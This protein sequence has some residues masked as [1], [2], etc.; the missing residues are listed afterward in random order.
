MS[1]GSPPS[2]EPPT[3]NDPR[4]SYIPGVDAEIFVPPSR[5]QWFWVEKL[6]SLFA[7]TPGRESAFARWYAVFTVV[8]STN[9]TNFS[10]QYQSYLND[11][12][13]T[14]WVARL[15]HAVAMPCIVTLMLMIARVL[16]GEWAAVTV[17]SVFALWWLVWARLERD[18]VWGGALLLL[19]ASVYGVSRAL[20]AAGVSPWPWLAVF[21]AIQMLSH[22]PELLPPRVSRSP[23]WVPVP[24]YLMSGGL[25]TGLRRALQIAIQFVYG[26]IAETLASPRLVCV[27]VLELLW[28]L[29]HRPEQRAAF[30][31]ASRKALASGNPALD[32]IGSGGATTLRPVR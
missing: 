25:A 1:H 10:L 22:T 20:S 5:E 32:Y 15:G 6:P 21:A 31:E 7:P 18:V 4:L 29:G 14:T 8:P 11:I 9:V 23:Y 16:L 13:H 27:L 17:A 12:F 19:A 2:A 26:A 28:V 24:E 3:R 30:K